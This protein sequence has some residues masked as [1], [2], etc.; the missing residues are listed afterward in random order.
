MFDGICTLLSCPAIGADARL[1]TELE[2][3]SK[4]IRH[5]V[6]TDAIDVLEAAKYADVPGVR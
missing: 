1:V 3:L 4:R 6:T 5:G 2:L